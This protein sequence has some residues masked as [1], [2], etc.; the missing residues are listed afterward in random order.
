MTHNNGSIDGRTFAIGVLSV[1]ACILF[2]GLVLMVSQPR[3]ALASG[4]VDRGGDY[5]MAT[6]KL[7]TN[8]EGLLVLDSAARRMNMYF[9]N[10]SQK[11]LQLIQNNV[12]LDKMPGAVVDPGNKRNNKP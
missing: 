2:T 3:T 6:I 5:I 9:A 7:D 4:E 12:P 1:T 11:K 8:A 10:V